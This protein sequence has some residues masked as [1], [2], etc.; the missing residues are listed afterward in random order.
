MIASSEALMR[1][2]EERSRATGRSLDESASAVVEDLEQAAASLN[3]RTAPLV[4]GCGVL[5]AASGLLLKAEPSSHGLAEFFVG[6]SVLFA[7]G[8]FTFLTRGLFLYAGRRNV[9]LSPSVDDVSFARNGLARKQANAYRGSWLAGIGLA[10]LI[11][12]I[13]FGVRISLG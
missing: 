4:P 5:V 12:G 2:V 10:C 7:V 3:G 6:L 1:R 13:L 9:G 8:G 11:I